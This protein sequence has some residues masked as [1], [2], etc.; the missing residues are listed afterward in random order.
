MTKTLHLTLVILLCASSAFAQL[1]ESLLNSMKPRDLGPAIM[2]GRVT[3]LAVYEEDPSIYYVA[4]ASGGL[5]KTVNNGGSWQNVFDN[6]STVS[7]GDVTINPSDPNI[8]WV[9]TGEANNRQSS[10]WGDGVYK[11][12]DGGKTWKNMGLRDSQHIGRIVV[13]PIDSDIVYVA[14]LGRLWGSNRERG[15]Y[16]TADGGLTWNNVLFVDDNTGAVDLAMDPLN[17]KTL[18]AA[19]Y[20][21]RRTSWGYNG[22]GPG[23]GIYKTTDGGRTWKKLGTGL[24]ATDVGRIGI[25]I[26][27][28]N[29]NIVMALVENREGG[30]F[31]SED[32]GETWTRMNSL[33][34][35]PMYF[36]Q[37]RIDPSDDKR[38]YVGGVQLH[39]S[40]DGGK[41]FRDDGAPNVHLDHHAFWINPKNPRHLLD[42]NDGGA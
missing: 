20:Q 35:R 7:I 38:V 12:T 4:S 24:P 1:S 31:R 27:R 41:T 29:P 19:M 33:N 3:D 15:V 14:A 2:S 18:Y 34:P 40:D 10:S 28:K 16:M 21:R 17:P 30:V 42:G 13:N 36:S 9:G 23:G 25:D 26:Y 8:V 39:I 22:G 37:I 32:K 6:Q 5:L 11:S